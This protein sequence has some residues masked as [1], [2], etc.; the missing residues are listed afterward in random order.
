ML[1]NPKLVFSSILLVW[2]FLAII[3]VVVVVVVAAS[4]SPNLIWHAKG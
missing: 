2:H 4:S 3:G 1:Y